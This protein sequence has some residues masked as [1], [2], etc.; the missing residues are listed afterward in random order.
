[1][2]DSSADGGRDITFRNVSFTSSSA[3][4]DRI[5]SSVYALSSESLTIR[6]P[7]TPFA[8]ISVCIG[9]G[10]SSR[11]VAGFCLDCRHPNVDI[12]STMD[13]AIGRASAG[14][15][16]SFERAVIC[17]PRLGLPRFRNCFAGRSPAGF[18]FMSSHSNSLPA[19][20]CS[21]STSCSAVMF[22]RTG[23]AKSRVSA[24]I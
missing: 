10:A 2:L 18:K 3:G 23:P 8:R 16:R 20:R 12:T 14:R 22:L 24:L 5:A 9:E 13:C 6:V 4:I 15:S 7:K 1:M 17:Q 21:E 11:V 19:A